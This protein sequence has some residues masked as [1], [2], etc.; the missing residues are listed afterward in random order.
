M[1]DLDLNDN[2]AQIVALRPIAEQLAGHVQAQAQ[3]RHEVAVV[4]DIVIGNIH[5][6][7]NNKRGDTKLGQV[8]WRCASFLMGS[9]A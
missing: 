7:F 4:P 5:V 6:L 3:G 1:C 8:C 9:E 2:A